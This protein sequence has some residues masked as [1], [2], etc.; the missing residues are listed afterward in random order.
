MKNS[1]QIVLFFENN[2]FYNPAKVASFLVDKVDNI[3]NP[4]ILPINNAPQ[5]ANLPILIFNQNININITAS[6]QNISIILFEEEISK[7]KSFIEIIFDCF[8]ENKFVRMGVVISS[9]LN[10]IEFSHIK[11]DINSD[12]ILNGSKDFKISWLNEPTINGL[13]VNR[14]SSYFSDKSNTD[15]VLEVLDFNT[16]IEENID[17][18]KKFALKFIEAC[19]EDN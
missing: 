9:M 1:I 16:K 18:D 15:M 14:W 5:D 6:F 8:K 19:K 12:M 13:I 11:L 7:A 3:G 17:I 10:K 4:V 2:T